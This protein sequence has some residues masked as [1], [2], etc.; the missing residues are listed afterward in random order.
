MHLPAIECLSFL[1]CAVTDVTTLVTHA[2]ET[3]RFSLSREVKDISWLEFWQRLGAV[4]NF[5]QGSHRLI[6]LEANEVTSPGPPCSMG[7]SA[8]TYCKNAVAPTLPEEFK[9]EE[10]VTTLGKMCESPTTVN[11]ERFGFKNFS[12][13]ASQ[14]V[15]GVRVCCQKAGN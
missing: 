15:T 2:L 5:R 6:S 13:Q 14:L 8:Y 11:M 3:L 4:W 10:M 7:A 1:V 9:F 12:Q